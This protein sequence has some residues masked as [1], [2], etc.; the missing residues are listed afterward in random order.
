VL[1]VLDE[2]ILDTRLVMVKNTGHFPHMEKPEI[3][4]EAIWNWLEEKI[5]S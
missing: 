3:C 4:N 1:K 5:Q 2:K